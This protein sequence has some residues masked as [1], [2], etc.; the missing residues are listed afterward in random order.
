M[1][2]AFIKTVRM[3]RRMSET[4]LTNAT[5]VSVFR[6]HPEFTRFFLFKQLDGDNAGQPVVRIK[7]SLWA[8]VRKMCHYFKLN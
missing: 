6:I 1:P 4:S 3:Y 5:R 8:L 7:I 2:R